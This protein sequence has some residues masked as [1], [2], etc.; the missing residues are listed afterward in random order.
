MAREPNRRGEIVDNVK[1]ERKWPESPDCTRDRLLYLLDVFE[2]QPDGLIVV[3]QF[4]EAVITMPG[5][6]VPQVSLTLG[7][8]R[9]LTDVAIGHQ[10]E[11]DGE[12]GSEIEV[13][14]G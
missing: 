3:R 11:L 6:Q 12:T 7:D 1:L 14:E 5:V 8:L 9:I 4:D 10:Y 2:G 13:I